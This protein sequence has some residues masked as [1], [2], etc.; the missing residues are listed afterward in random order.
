MPR[1]ENFKIKLELANNKFYP[2]KCKRSDEGILRKAAT[3]L[4][5][6]FLEYN[7]HYSRCGF[8][9]N[10]TLA[11]VGFHFSLE[12]LLLEKEYQEDVSTL[13]NKIEQL[14]KELEKY[15]NSL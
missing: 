2:Y 15:V 10:D 12:L 4:R 9:V 8:D 13:L 6:K 7:S 5:N 1:D 3:K 11:L 14:N